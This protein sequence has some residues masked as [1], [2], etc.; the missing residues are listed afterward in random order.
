MN[1]YENLINS[2]LDKN[3]TADARA[4][5]KKYWKEYQREVS[6]KKTISFWDF[7][8]RSITQL[9]WYYWT[10]S[11]RF[12]VMLA[13]IK[14]LED[15]LVFVSHFPKTAVFRKKGIPYHR[16]IRYHIENSYIRIVSF[17]DRL[18]MLVNAIL[19]M[20]LP[21][22]SIKYELLIEMEQVTTARLKKPLENFY[23]QL[24]K[25]RKIRNQIVHQREYDDP[26]LREVEILELV[27]KKLSNKIVR[28][29]C[30]VATEDINNIL[31][32]IESN[33]MEIFNLLL[34]IYQQV[35]TK[36]DPNIK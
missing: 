18:L 33:C 29:Y 27:K 30:R 3:I 32:K 19:R 34:P 14:Q 12:A 23:K 4:W 25:H 22:K 36:L 9:Q 35:R 7:K 13:A 2:E 17:F 26:E 21:D 1:V 6:R 11:H 20:G 8:P 28:L 31:K 10:V 16:Y 15:T 5:L 24:S